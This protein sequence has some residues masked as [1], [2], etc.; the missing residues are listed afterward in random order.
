MNGPYGGMRKTRGEPFE[1]AFLAAAAGLYY[2]REPDKLRGN[3]IYIGSEFCERLLPAKDEFIRA[4]ELAGKLDVKVTLLTPP[5]SE[6]GIK[7]FEE[8][9]RETAKSGEFDFEVVFNDWGVIGILEN[10]PRFGRI[11]GRLIPSHYT[12]AA[13]FPPAFMEFLKEKRI[14]AVELNPT[15]QFLSARNQ[16]AGGNIRAHVYYPFM[17]LTTTRFC[18]SVMISGRQSRDAIGFCAKECINVWGT[19]KHDRMK[20]RILVRGTAWFSKI[21]GAIA[22]LGLK[23]DRVV[24]NN[25]YFE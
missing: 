25:L 9:I 18:T 17:Y 23:P 10:F 19:V 13:G 24:F 5:F 6:K 11:M 12:G 8:F 7:L 3:R 16:L 2:F 14:R 15:R 4:L 1:Q 22:A 21:E 20:D